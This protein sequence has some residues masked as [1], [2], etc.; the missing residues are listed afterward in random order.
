MD[1]RA[2]RAHVTTWIDEAIIGLNL[3]PFAK[4]A[5]ASGGVT[6]ELS[7]AQTPHE[8]L[9]DALETATTLLDL[10]EQ[11]ERVLTTLLVYPRVLDD[12]DL[13]LDVV[14]TLRQ[15]LSEAGGDG[16]LQVATFHPDYRFAEVEEGD[17]SHYTNRS[18]Y[19]IIHFL[20]E[21]DVTRALSN[22]SE[23]ERIPD[24]NIDRLEALGLEGIAT[25]WSRWTQ[26]SS[27]ASETSD[28]LG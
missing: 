25:I 11:S 9:R 16:V 3:C 4:D 23:P 5:N 24:D 22:Y 18:P 21:A 10:D 28:E 7:D 8:A 12:F 1:E 13:Y 26:G 14:E 20:R 15:I 17:I 19:P 6:L 27:L 2:V